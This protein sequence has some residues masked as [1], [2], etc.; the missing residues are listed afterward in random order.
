MVASPSSQAPEAVSKAATCGVCWL[1]SA[2]C[3]ST[4]RVGAGVCAP[5]SLEGR[6]GCWWVPACSV[7]WLGRKTH[8]QMTPLHLLGDRAVYDPSDPQEIR[9]LTHHHYVCLHFKLSA[10]KNS[11]K[12]EISCNVLWNHALEIT[13]SEATLATPIFTKPCPKQ[14]SQPILKFHTLEESMSDYI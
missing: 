7:F 4:C 11:E 12:S 6:K 3:F 1:H 2:W 5:V 8:P 14:K 10:F 9:V 13:Y